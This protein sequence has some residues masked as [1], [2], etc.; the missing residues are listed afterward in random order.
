MIGNYRNFASIINSHNKKTINSNIT[1]TSAPTCNCGSK[2]S[3]PLNGDCL[4]SSLVYI[5]KADMPNIF[6]NY[7]HYIGSTEKYKTNTFKTNFT[8]TKTNSIMKLKVMQRNKGGGG[9]E[10][11]YRVI[12]CTN[13][14]TFVDISSDEKKTIMRCR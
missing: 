14:R 6:E 2:T 3:C 13:A 5:C 12:Y 11:K 7:P 1:K 8:S 10:F 4:Q 9:Q